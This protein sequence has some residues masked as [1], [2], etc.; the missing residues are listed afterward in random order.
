MENF[1]FYASFTCFK[2][3]TETLEKH[4]KYVKVFVSIKHQNDAKNVFLMFL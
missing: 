3:T 1:I 4:M 2:S